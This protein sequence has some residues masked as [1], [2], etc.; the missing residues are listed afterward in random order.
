MVDAQL[1]P[2]LVTTTDKY[3]LDRTNASDVK[4]VKLDIN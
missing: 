4:L 2:K 3:N 1:S